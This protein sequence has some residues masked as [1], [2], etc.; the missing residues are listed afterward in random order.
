MGMQCSEP[1]V[2]SVASDVAECINIEQEEETT[3]LAFAIDNSYLNERDDP[4]GEAA[5]A[6]ILISKCGQCA[7]ERCRRVCGC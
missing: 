2:A 6:P 5:G 1:G 4:L 7:N 3:I